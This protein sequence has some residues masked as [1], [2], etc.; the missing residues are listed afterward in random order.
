[1]LFLKYP[2]RFNL[3]GQ[4]MW[5]GKIPGL[6]RTLPG[7]DRKRVF[8]GKSARGFFQSIYEPEQGLLH[9]LPQTLE[10]Q[11]AWLAAMAISIA[12]GFTVIPAVTMLALGPVW[13][14][15]YAG[16]ARIQANHDRLSSR[17]LVAL[18]AYSGP[19]VRAM[20]RYK[21]R[22]L[23]AWSARIETP[24][25]QTPVDGSAGSRLPPQLLERKRHRP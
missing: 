1:M 16:R 19:M 7:G 24:P 8:W 22:L 2:E 15:Y 20:T 17:L 4:V 11:I 13:A 21:L 18:L 6:A 5:R 3:L 14:L 25:R 23:A 12:A 9:F 10:W